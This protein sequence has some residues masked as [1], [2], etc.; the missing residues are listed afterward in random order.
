[1]I[2]VNIRNGWCGS[3]PAALSNSCVAFAP[4]GGEEAAEIFVGPQKSGRP[5]AEGEADVLTEML[6]RRPQHGL[7]TFE[8]IHHTRYI[9]RS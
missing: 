6:Q 5:E 4:R 7:E 2:S 3:V 1:M 8:L 9:I